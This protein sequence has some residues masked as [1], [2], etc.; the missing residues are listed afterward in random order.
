[1]RARWPAGAALL[2]AL[3][4]AWVSTGVVHACSCANIGGPVEMA[5]AAAQEPQV[6]AF[7]GRVVGTRAAP[8]TIVGGPVIAYSFEVE[9]A[10]RLVPSVVEVRALDDGGGASCGFTFGVDGDWFVTAYSM[11]GA[12]QTGLCSGNVLTSELDPATLARLTEALPVFPE[13]SPVPPSDPPWTLLLTGAALLAAGA[14]AV[15]AFRR[16]RSVS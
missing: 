3:G 4:I 13:P 14:I 16:E 6:I 12:L 5:L 9:R 15:L 11:E 8:D 1:M 7:T 10:S 2:L